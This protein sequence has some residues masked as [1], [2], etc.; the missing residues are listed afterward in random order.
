MKKLTL[1][2]GVLIVS[3]F[4]MSAVAQGSVSIQEY[5]YHPS[6]GYYDQSYYLATVPCGHYAGVQA[7]TMASGSGATYEVYAV[8]SGDYGTAINS[9]TTSGDSIVSDSGL[10]KPCSFPG[11]PEDSE[12][13]LFVSIDVIYGSLI[14]AMARASV[15]WGNT[16]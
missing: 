16:Y 3:G 4:V 8:A 5:A 12:V 15:T 13:D 1:I 7:F 11:P 14:E 10:S 9:R 2:F 6:S